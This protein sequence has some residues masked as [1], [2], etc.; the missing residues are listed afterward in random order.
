VTAHDVDQQLF[1]VIGGE[2]VGLAELMEIAAAA[3]RAAGP[4]Q[5]SRR[6][7]SQGSRFGIWFRPAATTSS[8]SA[9]R[10]TYLLAVVALRGRQTTRVAAVGC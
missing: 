2:E 3:D 4:N 9:T 7:R 8:S 6:S 1:T 10:G 5:S